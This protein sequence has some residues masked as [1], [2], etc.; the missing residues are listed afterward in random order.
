MIYYVG[1]VFIIRPDGARLM[2]V[3]WRF[4]VESIEAFQTMAV[5]VARDNLGANTT[6]EFG[7]IGVSKHTHAA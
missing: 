1:S 6:V 5:G 4:Q 2:P 7:T 3:V